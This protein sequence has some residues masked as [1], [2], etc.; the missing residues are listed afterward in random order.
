M[1]ALAQ[2]LYVIAAD[3]A[4]I[5]ET[6]LENAGTLTPELVA[7]L[8]ALEGTFA[9]KL[10]RCAVVARNHEA[11]AKK[12]AAEADRQAVLARTQENAFKSI[13]AYM[14]MCMDGAGVQ[15]VEKVARIQ[16]NSQSS[17]TWTKPVEELPD[18]Y[19]RVTIVPN[20]R[21]AQDAL[22]AGEVL[23]EGFVVEKGSHLRLM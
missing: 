20:L 4:A 14:K 16:A 5:A 9:E 22:D 11:E 2:P 1:T 13:K 23:P 19:Q 18:E 17:I 3:L 8:D 12:H 15:K 21:R 10:A 7:Q 6:L